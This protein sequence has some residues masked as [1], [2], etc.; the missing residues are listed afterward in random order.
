MIELIQ[1][2]SSHYNEK[3]RWALDWKQLA[4]RRKNVLPGPHMLAV[5]RLTGQTGVPVVRF[6]DT[7]VYDSARIIDELERRCPEPPLYPADPAERVLALELQDH[8]DRDVGPQIRIALFSVMLGEGGY[9]CR[10][11]SEGHSELV[12]ALYRASFPL[13]KGPIRRG[14][15]IRGEQSIADGFDATLAGFDF[16]AKEVGPSG[17]LVGDR[18]SVADLTAAALLAPAV[19]VEHPAMRKPEPMPDSIRAWLDRW[20]NHP[21]AAWVG[22]MYAR[23]RPPSAALSP[24]QARR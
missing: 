8:F 4:H 14:N 7:V 19:Q 12:R 1:F 10:L 18:F 22:D 13:L 11:F 15:R 20:A 17:Y 2:P 3:A 16:V 24:Q 6:D 21:G 5:R 23:H 9:L